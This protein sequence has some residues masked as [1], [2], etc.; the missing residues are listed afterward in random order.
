[1]GA[2][3]GSHVTSMTQRCGRVRVYRITYTKNCSATSTPPPHPPQNKEGGGGEGSERDGLK[4]DCPES[5]RTEL[6]SCVK[7][8]V[9]VLGS[10]P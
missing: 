6:R 2:K 8:E 4:G 9:D 1:M 10:R 3:A 7:V 5:Y